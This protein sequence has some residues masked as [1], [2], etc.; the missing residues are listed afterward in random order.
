MI[1]GGAESPMILGGAE[2]P[3]ILGGADL[4]TNSM[5]ANEV[6]SSDK[7]STRTKLRI[8]NFFIISSPSV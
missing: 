4:G 3:M 5:A 6:A 7:T 2:S 8:I 1:L